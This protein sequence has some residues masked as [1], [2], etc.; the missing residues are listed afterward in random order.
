MKTN[1]TLILKNGWPYGLILAAISI[2]LS[3]L[4]Y[5]FDVNMFSISFAIFSGLIF[6]IAIP[7]TLSVLGCNSLRTK[8]AP[9]RTITYVDALVT[10][11]VILIIGFLLSNLY[12]YIFN[13]FI[14]PSY[15]KEQVRKLVEMLEKYNVPQ[16]KI[17]ETVASTEKNY[18][19]GIMLR[20][21]VVIAVVLALIIS[22]FIRKKDKIEEK[23][24]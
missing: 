12:N 20:N 13:N 16:E 3:L 21:S 9:E 22:I 8:F 1:F 5:I 17:D 7:V 2:V 11:L 19:I 15:M 4:L 24:V 10:C 18:S 23:I 14:D 6:L